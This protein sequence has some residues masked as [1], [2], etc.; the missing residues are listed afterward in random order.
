MGMGDDKDHT[1]S[2]NVILDCCC[3]ER[4]GA[5]M[6]ETSEAAEHL[7]ARCARDAQVLQ[8]V[9]LRRDAYM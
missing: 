6:V 8:W 5:G 1:A 2:R 9:C 7:R 3:P 4:R